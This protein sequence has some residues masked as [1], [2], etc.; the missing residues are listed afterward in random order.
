MNRTA[1][2]YA[3]ALIRANGLFAL[4]WLPMSQASIMMRLHYQRAD[5][6]AYKVTDADVM[7]MAAQ[8]G[9]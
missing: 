4:R 7:R 8:E 1:Y 2:L 5:K 6:L 9:Y 3:R